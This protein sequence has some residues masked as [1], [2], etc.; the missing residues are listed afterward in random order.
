MPPVV[1]SSMMERPLD[2]SRARRIFSSSSVTPPF[3]MA[4]FLRP[5]RPRA[6]EPAGD[7]TGAGGASVL[8]L[9]GASSAEGIRRAPVGPPRNDQSPDLGGPQPL[10]PQPASYQRGGAVSGLI[11]RSRRVLRWGPGR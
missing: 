3:G 1:S 4:L 8:R 2:V 6:A 7:D 9:R 11:P 10:S 5:A